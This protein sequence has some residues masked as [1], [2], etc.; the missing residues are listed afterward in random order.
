MIVFLFGIPLNITRVSITI[1]EVKSGIKIT[2]RGAQFN[3]SFYYPPYAIFI[4]ELTSKDGNMVVD[5]YP[6]KDLDNNLIN[7]RML[8]VLSFR[9]DTQR[10]MIISKDEFYYQVREYIL[11]NKYQVTSEY[12]PAQYHSEE[13]IA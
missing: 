7:N 8:K 11:Y 10:K 13:A 2:L 6:I 9:G 4:M 1:S 5:F 3:P 12:M